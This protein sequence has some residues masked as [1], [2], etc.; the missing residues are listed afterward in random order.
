MPS[1]EQTEKIKNRID[2]ISD[3]LY[4]VKQGTRGERHGPEDWLYHHWNAKD[5][6]WKVQKTGVTTIA[7]R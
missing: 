6:I 5:A 7:K 2:L 4:A 1:P 3:P